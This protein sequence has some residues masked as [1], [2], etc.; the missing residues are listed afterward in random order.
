MA[1][2]MQECIY[3]REQKKKSTLIVDIHAYKSTPFTHVVFLATFK[4]SV[5][6]H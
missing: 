4:E 6:E 5:Y 1:I 3:Q 2:F